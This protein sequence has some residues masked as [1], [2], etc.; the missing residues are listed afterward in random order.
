MEATMDGQDTNATETELS[1]TPVEAEEGQ[2]TD[3]EIAEDPAI[4]AAFAKIEAK[5]TGE[6]VPAPTP[7]PA[8]T[9]AA[10][11]GSTTTAP[12][13]VGTKPA[14]T[15]AAPT[16]GKEEATASTLSP[17][18]RQAAKRNG[19]EDADIDQLYAA[20]GPVAERTFERLQESYNGL[21]APSTPSW[22]RRVRRSS[23][24]PAAAAARP[25]PQGQ[26]SA[27]LDAALQRSRA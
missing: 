5:I 9:P 20:N 13:P 18:L 17:V 7:A 10:T 22:G 24:Q 8:K 4:T 15:P 2:R 25:P 27:G 3:A 14:A 26:Q 11:T 16:A 12:A 6:E 21:S 23:P 1:A 19:W